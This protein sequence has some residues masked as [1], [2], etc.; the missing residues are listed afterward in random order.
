MFRV[1]IEGGAEFGCSGDDTLLRA[2]LRA[3]LGMPYECNAGSCGACKVELLGGSVA[4]NWD[5][6]PALGERDRAKNR[7]LACQSVPRTDCTIKARLREEFRARD[8]PRRFRASLA[9]MRDLTHDMRE[10]SFRVEGAPGFRPGQYAL[11]DL[12]GVPGG[13]RAY[14]MANVDDGSGEWQFQVK[15]VPGGAGSAV[16]FDRLAHGADIGIDGPYGHAWLRTDSPRDIICIGGGSGLSAVMSIARGAAAQSALAEREVHFFYGARGPRDVCGEDMLAQLPGYGVRIHY[17]PVISMPSA[18]ERD[19]WQ[20]RT[21][22]VHDAV[23]EAFG[24]RLA[25]FEFYFAGPP[26]M[27]QAV[28][29][30]L[31][32]NKVPHAQIHYDSFY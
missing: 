17:H 10:F 23:R 31:A 14:S 2:G 21:G 6:A 29:S 15:R 27:A 22:F 12:E 1:R 18:I 8:L 28:Q 5:A 32:A 19:T 30:M 25:G 3:G 9:A 24:D 11:F 7:V 20:G 4:S 13:W 26:A 16:L